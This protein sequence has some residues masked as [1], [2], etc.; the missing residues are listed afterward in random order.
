VDQNAT[1]F[2]K[3][4]Q[5]QQYVQQRIETEGLSFLQVYSKDEKHLTSKLMVA[6]FSQSRQLF[7]CISA[8]NGLT[9]DRDHYILLIMGAKFA[10]TFAKQF[11]RAYLTAMKACP[12][13]RIRVLFE[14]LLAAYTD[15]GMPKLLKENK[16][17]TRCS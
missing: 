13:H 15:P 1:L 8:S 14:I 10:D 7:D 6:Q 9:P 5:A 4:H 3:L 17:Q 2:A 11:D 16:K 12:G